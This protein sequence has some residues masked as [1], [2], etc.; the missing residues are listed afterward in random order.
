[1]SLTR[2][3]KNSTK[4]LSVEDACQDLAVRKYNE[5]KLMYNDFVPVKAF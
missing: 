5:A 3:C 1:M 2:R 4:G